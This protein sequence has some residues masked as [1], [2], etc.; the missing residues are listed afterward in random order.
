MTGCPGAGSC[1]L[2]ATLSKGVGAFGARGSAQAIS[3]GIGLSRFDEDPNFAKLELHLGYQ[4]PLP[5][6]FAANFAAH[7]QSALRGVLP[8]SELFSLDGED[9]LS[10][11]TTGAL[12][13]D[14]GWVMRQE[15]SYP[16]GPTEEPIAVSGTPYLFGALGDGTSAIKDTKGIGYNSVYGAGL[17]L[18]WQVVSVS[19]EFGRRLSDLPGVS[20]TQFFFKGQVQ[21]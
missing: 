16:L 10:L 3:S 14:N 17:R 12:S 13:S 2:G 20:A 15:L 9:R 7:G 6:G 11:F 5:F 4:Q 19:M 1:K 8:T 18:S 21:F